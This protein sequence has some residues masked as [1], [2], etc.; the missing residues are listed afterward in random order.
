MPL[1]DEPIRWT[2][3]LALLGFTIALLLRAS[4]GCLA[5]LAHLAAAFHFAHGWSHA[6]AYEHTALRAWEVT[7]WRWGGGVY[8]NYTLRGNE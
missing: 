1:G 3:R 6:Q 4:I 7:G 8:V 2:V 5:Y